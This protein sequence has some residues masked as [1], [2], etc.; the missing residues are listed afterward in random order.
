MNNFS[1]VFKTLFSELFSS[2]SKKNN[3]KPYITLIILGIL[4]FGLSIFYTLGMDVILKEVNGEQYLPLLF[5]SVALIFV[6][7]T[8][9]FRAQMVLFSNKDHNILTP[10]PITKKTIISAKLLIFYLQ[11][12]VYSIILFLPTIVLYGLSHISF[13]FFGLILLLIIPL[14]GVLV[15]SVIGFLISFLV[16]RFK[17]AKIISTILYIGLFVGLIVLSFTLNINGTGEEDP[18]VFLKAI[19]KMRDFF[20]F[21]WIYRGFVNNE[22]IYFLLLVGSSFIS[23]FIVIFLYAKF[24]EAF[25]V[26]LN[27]SFSRSKY[28]RKEVKSKSVVSSIISKDI[29]LLFS[30]PLI[31][32]SSFSG[33]LVGVIMTTFVVINFNNIT[34]PPEA[35]LIVDMVK[36]A[37]P[38]I[39]CFFCAMMAITT[40]AI[41]L[42]KDSFWLIKTLPIRKKDYYTAKLIENQIFNGIFALI[43]SL[44][45]ICVIPMN[46]LDIINLIIYP[47]LYIFA[48]GLFGLVINLKHP[49]L[50]WSSFN[51]IKNS[52]SIMI[53]TFSE[54]LIALVLIGIF[55]LFYLVSNALTA[56]IVS[57]LL[58]IL[59]ILIMIQ[60]LNKDGKKWFD[61]IVC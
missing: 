30:V 1:V 57:L 23:A 21:D 14:I 44:I 26:M 4:F 60:V 45:I 49:R 35:T 20:L 32:L 38:I 48:L 43:S 12:L 40:M 31:L 7:F 16:N 52:A 41:S 61:E 42:E 29:K 39:I 46:V 54:M 53:Y 18:T 10:L 8:T 13:L 28:N 58:I 15:S 50:H 33:G 11:E 56:V 2:F 24:Y 25:Y 19:A 55:I 22:W 5:A 6:V 17:I 9:I 37:S 3:R 27:R 59:F 34:V 47:Q 36:S 51:E